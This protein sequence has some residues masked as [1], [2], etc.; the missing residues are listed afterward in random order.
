[1]TEPAPLD[2]APSPP[3]AAQP[4][5]PSAPTAAPPPA[6]Q[7]RDVVVRYGDVTALEGCSLT[8]TAGGVT[9]LIGMNGAGKSTLFSSVMG[10]VRPESGSISIG[11]LSAS[12]ARSR[13]A[14]AYMP[15][16]E[17]VDW[18]FPL[19]VR[20][21][22]MMGR[23]GRMG[24][25]RR[26]R[27]DDASAVDRA[28]SRAGLSDLSHRQIGRLSGGQRKRVFVARA[29]AQEAPLLLLDEP[30]AGV[31]RRSQHDLIVLLREL[32]EQGRTILVSTHDLHSVTDLADDAALLLRR[33]LFHGPVDQ[34]VEPHR[35]AQVFGMDDAA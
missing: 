24:P 27:R 20:D 17:R 32:A 30:F 2:P 10:A 19:S 26:L 29:I 28:I 11:G 31:D 23:Y 7:V 18:D 25:T 5:P 1:M 16:S 34:A 21:V 12:D 14:I 13:S 8:L 4:P 22:V 6:L 35:L 9:V 15:Q 33:M 3:P